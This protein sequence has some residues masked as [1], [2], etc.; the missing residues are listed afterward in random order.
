MTL[1]TLNAWGGRVG[2]GLLDFFSRHDAVDVFLLQEVF[3]Q[4]TAKTV[5]YDDEMPQL[6]SAINTILPRHQG[7][8]SPSEAGEWGL[9]AFI[10][11]EI[12]IEIDGEFFVYRYRDAMIGRDASTVG[13]NL[14]YFRIFSAGKPITLINFHGLWTGRG[15]EDSA[16]RILQ[17]QNII[18]FMKTLTG[19]FI[20]VGDFNLRPDTQSMKMLEQELG[21]KN[22]IE[23]HRISSTRTSLYP[24]SERFADYV[25]IS[26]GVQIK[27]FKVLPDEVSDHTP[28]YLEFN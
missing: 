28:L 13:R 17:S 7:Y 22:L 19:D 5:F 21:L 12:K 25:L 4:G 27:D 11:K 15:K 1:I 10:N 24:K 14:Q 8:F 20:L 9:A 26:S 2:A 18:K 16:E 3:H 6:F 23:E